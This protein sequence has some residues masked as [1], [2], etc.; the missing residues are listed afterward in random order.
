MV[1]Q[2]HFVKPRASGTCLQFPGWVKFDGVS[3]EGVEWQIPIKY[4]EWK[5]SCVVCAN[6]QEA[7]QRNRKNA[8]PSAG[9][10]PERSTT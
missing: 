1:A 2:L 10:C 5:F 6:K 3:I 8:G 4:N 9:Y 7:R